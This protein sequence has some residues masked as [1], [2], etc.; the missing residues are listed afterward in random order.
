MNGY[1]WLAAAVLFGALE[2]AT[3]SLVSIW[4]MGGALAALLASLLGASLGVQIAV[5]LTVSAALLLGLRPFAAKY[6]APK[7]NR[8]N[9][10]RILGA[11]AVVTEEIRNLEGTGAVKVLGAE[12]SARSA[13]GESIPKGTVVK[14]LRIE[15]VK[16]F[17]EPAAVPAAK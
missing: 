11:E 7:K 8:L 16:V 17:V 3:V 14:I 2:A 4:F 6:A 12:W 1:I 10:D 5:F 13:S 15:G 9:T